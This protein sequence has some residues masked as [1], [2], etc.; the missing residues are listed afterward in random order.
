MPNI[1]I[2]VNEAFV[3]LLDCDKRTMILYGGAG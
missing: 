3:P 1:P 2:K